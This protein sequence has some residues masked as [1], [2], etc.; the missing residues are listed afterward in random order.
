VTYIGSD[1]DFF[2]LWIE[3]GLIE[4]MMFLGKHAEFKRLHGE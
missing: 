3:Y 1:L 4:L 2:D